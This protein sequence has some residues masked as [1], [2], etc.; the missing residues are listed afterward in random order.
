VG[1]VEVVPLRGHEES[2]VVGRHVPLARGWLRQFDTARAPLFY[3]GDPDPDEYL[4][5]LRTN[6]VSYVALPQRRVDFSS[7]GEARLLRAGMP[8]LDEVWSDGS[9][10]VLRVSG[11]GMVRGGE[12]VSADR[13]AVV[14]DVPRPGRVDVAIWWSRWTSVDGPDGCVRA[15]ERDGWTTL[16]AGRP[17]RYVIS[18]AWLPGGRCS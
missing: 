17:G 18:S 8:E 1:R 6:G 12:L 13:S 10:T 9:W 2:L 15:G 5:W 4:R 3:A 11:S 14:V 16:D 7:H